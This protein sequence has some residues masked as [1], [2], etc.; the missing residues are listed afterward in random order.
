MHVLYVVYKDGKP[1]EH[2]G[3]SGYEGTGGARQMIARLAREE[4]DVL[5]RQERWAIA[6]AN[7]WAWP[8]MPDAAERKRRIDE[9]KKRYTVET[10]SR[11]R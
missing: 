9:E 7:N 6:A 3:Q 2:D 1:A 11:V 8:P 10:Y 4:V 5:I